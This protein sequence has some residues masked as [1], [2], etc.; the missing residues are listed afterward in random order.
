MSAAPNQITTNEWTNANSKSLYLNQWPDE[1][2]CKLLYDEGKQCGGCS[3]FAPFNSDWG[4][5]CQSKSRHYLETTFEHFTCPLF[6]GEGWGPH[7]FTEDAEFHC[8][9]GGESGD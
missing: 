9:C 2:L 8:T 4:L 1:P 6:I 7:S 3:F 5:C